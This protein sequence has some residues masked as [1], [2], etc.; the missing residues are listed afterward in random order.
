MGSSRAGRVRVHAAGATHDERRGHR[1]RERPCGDARASMAAAIGRR[2][3]ERRQ[4]PAA[5]SAVAPPPRRRTA[6]RCRVASATAGG[7][8]SPGALGHARGIVFMIPTLPRGADHAC[9]RSGKG[10]AARALTAAA[11]PA[12]RS[13][14]SPRPAMRPPRARGAHGRSRR[15]SPAAGTARRISSPPVMRGERGIGSDARGTVL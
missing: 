3:R 5:P 1:L 4:S 2:P 10:I 14:G 6:A 13:T 9:V 11:A 15:P 7:C 12:A 8:R